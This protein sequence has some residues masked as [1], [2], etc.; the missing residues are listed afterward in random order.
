MK[1]LVVLVIIG[2]VVFL[3]C[4]QKQKVEQKKREQSPITC[5]PS[6]QFKG[7]KRGYV[8]KTENGLTGYYRDAGL[9][10]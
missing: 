10:T 8:F 1:A 7:F 6:P 2:I 5:I 9:S 4:F 3:L